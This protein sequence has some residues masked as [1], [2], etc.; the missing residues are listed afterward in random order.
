MS[1]PA[2]AGAGRAS[3]FGNR[4]NRYA[5]ALIVLV[6]TVN[7]ID[8]SIVS[9]LL[10]PIRQELQLDDAQLG[11]FMGTAFSVSY[12]VMSLAI[13]Q[14]ADRGRRNR[15]IA[16][17]VGFWS[18]MTALQG[19]AVGF[20]SLVLARVAVAV[21]EAG[22]GPASNS[23]ISD[24]FPISRRGRALAAFSFGVPIGASVG[25]LIGGWMRELFGWRTAF[26]VVGLPGLALALLVW[27]TLRE[28][29]RG[30]WDDAPRIERAASLRETLAFLLHLPAFRQ[31]A[32]G[33]SLQVVAIN[34][35][36][37]LPVFFER[38]HGF[39]PGVFGT[40]FAAFNLVSGVAGAYLGGWLGDR[41]GGRDARWYMWVPAL[42]N[43]VYLP[44]AFA[45]YLASDG[46]TALT[47]F[48]IGNLLPGA[49][50]VSLATAQNLA[51]ARMR[52]RTAALMLVSSTFVGG[53]G[54]Q[55]VGILSDALVQARG[56]ES[57]RYALLITVAGALAWASLHYALA[58][59][60]LRRDL[61][62]KEVAGSAA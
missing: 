18:A 36:S 45:F 33:Y 3:E 22:S 58:A 52:A 41:L 38:S 14:L 1:T 50:G 5:L 23:M 44:F 42:S 2:A 28:P 43:L 21:G 25:W 48:A 16:L 7:I 11:F 15:I 31:L 12:A 8:R 54:P 49:I 53:L 13:A 40:A 19:A 46:W 30:Y 4:Y 27:K 26:W 59:R 62:A 39:S 47:L 51:P 6:A 55:L 20:G 60:S 37:F 32:I 56:I 35:G 10:E 61:T 34:A 24:L 29:T 17:A 9:M 57:M